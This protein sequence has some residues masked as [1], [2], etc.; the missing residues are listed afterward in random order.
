MAS[1][2][3]SHR[4]KKMPAQAGE[5]PTWLLQ[6][7]KV[8]RS[9]LGSLF[10]EYDTEWMDAQGKRNFYPLPDGPLLVLLLFTAGQIWTTIRRWD[11]QKEHHYRRLQGRAVG[12]EIE[13]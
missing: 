5:A 10:E 3:F 1:I 7:F 11:A 2:K 12:I 4:Y 8:E 13:G 6:V 9:E